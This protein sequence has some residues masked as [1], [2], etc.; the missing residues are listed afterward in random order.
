MKGASTELKEAF[1]KIDERIMDMSVEIG[2]Y[3]TKN[4]IVYKTSRNFAYLAIQNKSNRIRC[5]IRTENDRMK[6]PKKL[7]TKIP[8]THGYGNITRQLFVNPKKLAAKQSYIDNIM[9]LLE[10]SYSCIQ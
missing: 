9:E 10:Q 6:D 3:T 5:L 8:K 4:E 7:T 1:H 2:R